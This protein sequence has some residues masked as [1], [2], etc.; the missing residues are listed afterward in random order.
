[1]KTK[2]RLSL[3]F[4]KTACTH[5]LQVPLKHAFALGLKDG[6]IRMTVLTTI[7]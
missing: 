4:A 1:M 3:T 2:C 6:I 5:E 7:G